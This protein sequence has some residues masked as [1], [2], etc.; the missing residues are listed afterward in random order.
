MKYRRSIR[1]QLTLSMLAALL[2]GAIQS[3]SQDLP[4]EIQADILLTEAKSHIDQNRWAEVV[5]TMK[6][7]KGLGAPLPNEFHFHYAKASQQAKDGMRSLSEVLTYLHKSEGNGKYESEAMNLFLAVK[8][9][10]LPAV[11]VQFPEDMTELRQAKLLL[12]SIKDN[13]SSK[14]Y[15]HTVIDCRQLE[16]LNVDLPNDFQLLYGRALL[17]QEYF[18]DSKKRLTHFLLVTER[19]SSQYK[20]ALRLHVEAQQK[21]QIE[22]ARL[23]KEAF[24]KR[25]VVIPD[26]GIEMI[27]I[28]KGT[29]T[30]GSPNGESG[31]VSNEG[32]LTAVTI[33]NMFS[34]GK[35]EVTQSQWEALMRNNPSNW[36]GPNLPVE[37]VS[38]EDAMAFCEV[39]TLREREVGRLLEGYVYTL[40]TEAQWEYACRA[41]TTTRFSFGDSDSDLG[42]YGWYFRN[43]GHQTHPVGKKLANPWG[44]HDMHGNV[45][46]WCRDWAGNYPGGTITD[47]AGADSNSVRVFRGGSWGDYAGHC[48][49]ADRGWNGP[50]A[51]SS[52]YGFRVAL[53]QVSL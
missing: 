49:S 11:P 32:P 44:L 8:N 15:G 35:T 3:F 4:V 25:S 34:L 5:A 42:D 23:I 43:S 45:E 1:N 12:A 48:R 33:S 30:M 36:T 20:E 37:Q 31:R 29:F 13:E 26:L 53:V 38:W 52:S 19:G 21:A 22:E 50:D 24:F 27:P 18:A 41:G 10:E 46:E 28:P 39:L 40:P 2:L 17:R 14:R 51:T 47:P 9:G 7:L 16:E 6:K